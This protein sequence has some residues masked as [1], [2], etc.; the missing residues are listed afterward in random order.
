MTTIQ[1]CRRASSRSGR[2]WAAAA[3]SL[4]VAATL[5]GTPASAQGIAGPYLAAEHA[6]RISDFETAATRYGQALARQPDNTALIDRALLHH[7]GADRMAQATALA[8]RLQ[9]LEPGRHMAALMLSV[10]ALR[11]D[12]AAEA[13]S[14]LDSESDE[15]GSFV[16]GLLQ[17]WM[18]YGTGELAEARTILGDIEESG[19]GGAAGRFLAAYHLGLMA[20]AAGEDDAALAP[21]TRAREAAQRPTR[22]LALALA[23]VQSRLGDME[24]AQAVLDERLALSLSDARLESAAAMLAGGRPL[25]RIVDSAADGAAEALYGLSRY[26]IGGNTE[27]VGLSYARLAVHLR[28]DHVD[29]ILLAAEFLAQKQRYALSVAAYDAVP[30]GAPEALDARIGRASA[31]EGMEDMDGAEETLRSAIGQWPDEIEVHRALGDLLRRTRA[32]E[33]AAVAYDGAVALVNTPENRHWPLYYQRGIALER[34]KQ[35]PRAE[36]DF[37][38]ALELEPDQPHVLN[39]LGYSWVEMGVNLSEAQAMIERAVEQRPEDGYIVDSLGWV[40]YRLGDF[41]GAVKHLGRAVEL[42][43]VDPVIND[44]YGD[45]LWMVGRRVEAEFQWRRALSFE[46]EEEDVV[47]RIRRKLETGLDVVM[48]EEEAAGKPAIIGQ[49]EPA[50]ED[51]GNDGG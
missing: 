15:A 48:A 40:L 30:D 8:R 46:P 16:S 7:L 2:A 13:G 51:A 45:A 10:D 28:P 42:R 1:F 19:T 44:H 12:D 31:F 11:R 5:G 14:Y 20:I 39:Y 34:S 18:A 26:L 37:R 49:T 25:G 27:L 4:A 36:A 41:E 9:A 47:D 50:A 3:A 24:A 23:G 22:R 29:A 32:F 35:W 21:L 38:T 17:A 6:A 43:P 33:A